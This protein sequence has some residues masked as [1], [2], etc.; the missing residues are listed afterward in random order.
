MIN[1]SQ[2]LMILRK[3]NAPLQED[4]VP[5]LTNK[6]IEK[7]KSALH[8]PSGLVEASNL[9]YKQI[10][11]QFGKETA[12]F[13]FERLENHDLIPPAIREH[14]LATVAGYMAAHDKVMEMFSGAAI[15]GAFDGAQSNAATNASGMAAPN[16]PTKKKKPIRRMRNILNNRL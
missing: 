7:F 15:G 14:D 3:I 8:D 5:T 9:L 12:D 11:E 13:V 16:G 1:T 6:I 4:F 10:E 2:A